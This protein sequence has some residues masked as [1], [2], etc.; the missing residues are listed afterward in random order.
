[1]A[2]ALSYEVTGIS[3]VIVRNLGL[4]I[5]EELTAVDHLGPRTEWIDVHV[6]IVP[7]I[8]IYLSES[9][10][11]TLLV[12]LLNRREPCLIPE[13]PNRAPAWSY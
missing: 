12:V 8:Q 1:M 6:D 13:G 7:S 5:E 11:T 2:Y 4:G 10:L 3:P 9:T